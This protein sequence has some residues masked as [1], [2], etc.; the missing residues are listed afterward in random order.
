MRPFPL[1]CVPSSIV[2]IFNVATYLHRVFFFTFLR[3]GEQ[4]GCLRGMEVA[5]FQNVI[6]KR[7]AV[8]S[9]VLKE[10]AIIVH[11]N[12]A[13]IKSN[14]GKAGRSCIL[15]YTQHRRRNLEIKGPC[16]LTRNCNRTS[17]SDLVLAVMTRFCLLPLLDLFPSL[18]KSLIIRHGTYS[19]SL[20]L[21]SSLLLVVIGK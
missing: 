19:A 14:S 21:Y 1:P 11:M 12:M 15:Q 9:T 16:L 17:G 6:V 8:E 10:N 20:S 5:S 7:L 18:P 13:R 3:Y 2:C 4:I